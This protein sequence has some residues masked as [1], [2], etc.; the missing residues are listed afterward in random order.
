MITFSG[1]MVNRDLQEIP[2]C[3]DFAVHLGRI[4]R[5]GGAIWWPDLAHSI[6]VATIVDIITN[7]DMPTWAWALL[8]D[9]H[10][11]ITGET[12]Y[13]WKPQ[14]LGEL[15]DR[16]DERLAL[17]FHLPPKSSVDVEAIKEADTAA[18]V[19]EA[20]GLGLPSWPEY[21]QHDTGRPPEI[22][23]RHIAL[24]AALSRSDFVRP[25]ASTN[26]GSYAVGCFC[27]ILQDIK[28]QKIIDAR[29]RLHC[30]IERLVALGA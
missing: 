27:S 30:E 11:A 16:I 18:L 28:R 22:V 10:E 15:Q 20:V 9:A 12:P 19:A 3:L 24:V 8:H 2:S 26:P 7:E 17:E 6:L 13:P 1:R 25:E 29:F 23:P 5:Y 21:C 14:S 4:C